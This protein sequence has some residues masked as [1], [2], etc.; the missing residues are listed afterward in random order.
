MPSSKGSPIDDV[1]ALDLVDGVRWYLGVIVF[2]IL[3]MVVSATPEKVV[4]AVWVVGERDRHQ[5][6]QHIACR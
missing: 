6:P 4:I 2:G 5:S 1:F 3:C